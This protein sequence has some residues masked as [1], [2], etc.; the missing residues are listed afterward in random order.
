[1]AK[2]GKKAYFWVLLN[3]AFASKES[4]LNPNNSMKTSPPLVSIVT[5]NFRKRGIT[6][7]LLDT[8]RAITYPNYELILVD[9]GAEADDRDVYEAHL[10]G[11]RVLRSEENLGFA[12]GNN[13]GIAQAKGDYI[14]LINNDTLVPPGFLQPLV[15]VL[16]SDERIGIVSPK[17]YYHEQ[18]KML[19]YAGSKGINPFTGRGKNLAK[20]ML[21]DG[22][23]ERTG[24]TDLAHGACMMVRREV[25]EDIGL[26]SELYFMYYEEIDFCERARRSGWPIYFTSDAY[27]HHRESV[28]IGK[29]STIKTYYLFRNRWLYMRRFYHG[30]PYYVFVLYFLTL[31]APRHALQFWLKG[32]KAHARAVLRGLAWHAKNHAIA[33][34]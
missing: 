5:V 20:G 24:P 12:G 27:I 32:E 30:I 10:P 17:I 26:L 1:M 31:G 29:F 19:Q 11:I 16:N 15:A 3:Q 9:N 4:L 14:L 21:D 25:F 28:S 7:D 6:C 33:K 2:L 13:L 22:I 8:V 18:P 34:P 23:F